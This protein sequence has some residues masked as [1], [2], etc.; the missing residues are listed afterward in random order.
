[1]HAD[2]LT[3]HSVEVPTTSSNPSHGSHKL[4][5]YGHKNVFGELSNFYPAAIT[6][7]GKK[8][9]TTEHY[10]QAMK[11][12]AGC[13]QDTIRHASTPS[14]A[15]KLGGSRAVAIRSDWEAVKED[16]MYIACY[17]KFTQHRKLGA[18]L[19][20]TGDA[21]LVEH[22]HRDYEWGDGGDGSGQNKLGKVLMR[23]RDTLNQS[24]DSS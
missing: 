21:I 17:A 5:F 24:V 11:F 13:H 14:K 19:L 16:V 1:M 6:V 18:L 22:T 7:D 8:Y 3:S 12:P 2:R 4:F 15:K 10:F 23:V 20:Q 9:P